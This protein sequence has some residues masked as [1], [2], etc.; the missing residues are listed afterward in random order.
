MKD[1]EL[2]EENAL[3]S[4]TGVWQPLAKQLVALLGF[5]R[6]L[7][8]FFVLTQAAL[9]AFLALGRFPQWDVIIIG[10]IACIT[11][12]Y[13]LVAFNDLLDV[14]IDKKRFEGKLRELDGFDIGSA[15]ERHPLAQGTIGLGL[16]LS[17]ILVMAIISMLGI[18]YINPVL[19]WILP[20]IA[21]FVTGYSLLSRRSSLKTISV[22]IAVTLGGVAGWLAVSSVYSVLFWLFVAWTFLWEIGGR[23]IPNDFNDV[24]ED[25]EIGIKTFPATLGCK[26]AAMIIIVFL[27]LTII[28][29]L[30]M[31]WISTESLVWAI[32][33]LLFGIYFLLVPGW[34][35]VRKA[36]PEQSMKLF[37]RSCLYPLA[38]LLILVSSLF[39]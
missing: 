11:G 4:A 14:P 5:S 32:V 23:N 35:L 10:S 18:Y 28:V 19:I 9:G 7:I 13:S 12:S 1:F 27:I 24:E 3:V 6:A 34:N 22:A 25:K 26:A 15:F 38:M 37:N 36:V 30:P 21:T 31:I 17:W 2:T 20:I 39:L 33:A 16:A 29:S 8:G